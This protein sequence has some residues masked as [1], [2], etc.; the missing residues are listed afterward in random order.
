[1]SSPENDERVWK[2]VGIGVGTDVRHVSEVDKVLIDGRRV[3]PRE[4]VRL[5][6]ITSGS[7]RG[8]TTSVDAIVIIESAVFVLGGARGG[9]RGTVPVVED[10]S[11]CLVGVQFQSRH[12]SH[13]LVGP[14]IPQNQVTLLPCLQCKT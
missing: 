4:S 6:L 5:L 7:P 14:G 8:L 1:M 10:A 11:F 13:P 12:S 9:H 2:A 3:S